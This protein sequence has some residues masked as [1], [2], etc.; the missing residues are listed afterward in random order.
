MANGARLLCGLRPRWSRADRL[1][2][3]D[4][5]WRHGGDSNVAVQALEKRTAELKQKQAQI[6]VMESKV[7]ELRAKQA[8]FETARLEALELRQ[9]HPIQIT[10]EKSV[11]DR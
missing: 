4:Q 7:E 5:L 3:H 1:G 9:N 6:A 8:Y 11:G 2:D 10:A